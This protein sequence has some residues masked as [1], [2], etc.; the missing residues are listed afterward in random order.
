MLRPVQGL[1]GVYGGAELACYVARLPAVVIG[2]VL[3]QSA[4]A[5]RE[6]R[7]DQ[8]KGFGGP[9]APASGS[10]FDA[11]HYVP[12]A[13]HAFANDGFLND[14]GKPGSMPDLRRHIAARQ[15]INLG[16]PPM[17][18]PQPPPAYWQHL[19]DRH[20]AASLRGLPKAY[21]TPQAFGTWVGP[22]SGPYDNPYKRRHSV[23]GAFHTD[24]YTNKD[25]GE[26]YP[27]DRLDSKSEMAYP[28]Y[29]PYPYY[30]RYDH[31][32]DHDPRYG[33]PDYKREDHAY[34]V[35]LLRHNPYHFSSPRERVFYAP[36]L[37]NSH[38]S[39]IINLLD[40][41]IDRVGEIVELS[42]PDQPYGFLGFSPGPR[43]FKG[44]P[45]NS[46]AVHILR[47]SKLGGGGWSANDGKRWKKGRGGGVSKLTSFL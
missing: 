21:P 6:A 4:Y 39:Y 47:H 9:A 43:G 1:Q 46:R 31:D 29:R 5:L 8:Q 13:A 28:H 45:A 14:S 38:T 37:R 35:N 36:G 20:Y 26:I 7:R 27:E 40:S 32:H 12:D 17:M 16:Y 15:S 23:V 42:G 30:E 2:V 18:I 24:E 10:E 22:R 44:P 25:Y 34:G 41:V 33:Y 11:S 19:A 3:V